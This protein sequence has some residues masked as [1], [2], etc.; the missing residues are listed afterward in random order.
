MCYLAA[1]YNKFQE[2]VVVWERENGFRKMRTLSA[3]HYFYVEE[4]EG[5]YVSIFGKKLSKHV[6]ETQQDFN[7]ARDIFKR[8]GKT[9]YE[10]DIPPEQKILFEN[11]SHSTAPN[12]NITFYDIEVDYDPKIGFSSVKDPYAPVSA[13][14]LHHYWKNDSV[15]LA[16]LP[17]NW[18]EDQIDPSLR[19]QHKI[20][21]F[22]SEKE[23]L[24]RFLHE[25]RDSDIMS[26]YNSD[27]FD[28]PYVYKR[29]LAVCGLQ[30][31]NRMSFDNARK[32]YIRT[33]TKFN[34]EQD[35]LTIG[36]RIW[37]DYLVLFK[38]YEADERQSYKLEAISEEILP[39]LPKLQYSGSLAQLYHRDFNE[40]LRYNI[41]DTE[42]LKGFEDK[43][44]YV[45]LSIE[46]YHSS[47]GM[48]KHISGTL[49][50]ADCAI[51]TYC[52]DT[53]DG[54][55]PDWNDTMDVTDED[56]IDGALV[57][58]PKYGKHSWL[59]AIDVES[60]YPSAV[61]SINISPEKLIGQFEETEGAVIHIAD[62][63]SELLTFEINAT[64]ERIEKTAAEWKAYLHEFN[65]SISGYGT[66]FMQ[67]DEGIIPAVL[68]HW[69][70]KRKEYK[71]LMGTAFKLMK[72][73]VIINEETQ[74][75][76]D[77]E[78][79]K[80][81]YYN[82]LQYVYKI[83]L[84]SLFGALSNA[85]FRFY[86]KRL[87]E[88]I[89]AT[90]RMILRHQ[91][92]MVNHVLVDEYDYKGT[93]V[94]YG[95][96]DSTY[97]PT[98]MKDKMSAL[99]IADEVGKCV[100]NS[101]PNFMMDRF[102][103]IGDFTKKIKTE[104]ELIADRGI[105]VRKKHYLLHVVCKDT[106]LNM[107]KMKIM[108][109]KLKKTT[110]PKQ[111]SK[112]LIEMVRSMLMIDDW[113]QF[114]QELVDYKDSLMVAD[115][116]DIGLPQGIKKLDHYQQIFD[117][118]GIKARLPGHVAAS[119]LY[120]LMLKTHNDLESLPITSNSKIKVFKLKTKQ[121]NKFTSIA[122]PTDAEKLPDWFVDEYA[123]QI[124]IDKHIT[125]V[126]NKP[127]EPILNVM[128]RIVPSKQSMHTHNILGI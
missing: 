96:T 90:G 88:S 25:I 38:K 118:E 58:E 111:I 81:R 47:L 23:L 13:I 5:E 2:T 123:D 53:S 102:N 105:F 41:R 71:A 113:N 73:I 114:Q 80:Y 20:I 14:A 108:G 106:D 55:V 40:F 43:L 122:I 7:Q 52:H 121:L 45:A 125:Q 50:L 94:L 75:Q 120:N 26:G 61:R 57:L 63:T 119:I 18:T 83:R 116:L 56:A 28:D 31:A 15:V 3:P 10:S 115:L 76:H 87:A 93:A 110:I 4:K 30:Y 12:A 91:C 33:V 17:P 59:G 112:K 82:R 103:C 21:F 65:F 16:V 98:F 36:G 109:L 85:F 37:T 60:L 84:N 78:E 24:L 99:A 44:G 39:H 34:E 68:T 51:I 117:I 86:D 127:L 67:D 72:S 89:T 54:K 70:G 22:Q 8:Q 107:D 46:I 77:A 97:F 27:F 74:K 69:F 66:V 1:E 128:D 95:D 64:S 126:V 100:N 6:F 32:P 19:S 35:V 48:F 92:A 42:I 9:L 11:Y 62:A 101:F 29:L 49:R 79:D 104:R 124:L